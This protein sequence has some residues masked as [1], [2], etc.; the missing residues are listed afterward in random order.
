MLL[1]NYKRVSTQQLCKLWKDQSICSL[2][3][4]IVSDSCL[5]PRDDAAV[6]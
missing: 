1:H 6:L 2:S 5:Y 4:Q 3:P